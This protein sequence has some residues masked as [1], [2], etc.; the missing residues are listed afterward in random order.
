[1]ALIS[2]YRMEVVV[3]GISGR[4]IN[5]IWPYSRRSL[6]YKRCQDSWGV[7][8]TVPNYHCVH[9]LHPEFTLHSDLIQFLKHLKHIAPISDTIFETFGIP[10]SLSSTY[11]TQ[12]S[13]CI[14]SSEMV[15]RAAQGKL[16]IGQTVIGVGIVAHKT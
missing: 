4:K 3:V 8:I 7:F 2:G 10:Y 5:E 12:T 15:Y 14:P 6:I 16:P 1:M 11:C 13:S 9:V